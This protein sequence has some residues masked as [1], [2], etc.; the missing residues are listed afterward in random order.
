M[1]D[2]VRMHHETV[3]A[4]FARLDIGDK[5]FLTVNDLR[6]NLGEDFAGVTAEDLL[7]EADPNGTGRIYCDQFMEY[8]L[9]DEPDKDHE[10]DRQMFLTQ[11]RQ[12]ELWHNWCKRAE[13]ADLIMHDN[14]TRT[15]GHRGTLPDAWT[16]AHDDLDK[17]ADAKKGFGKSNS[18]H[19]IFRKG[20]QTP[21][22][23]PAT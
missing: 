10:D 7:A 11:K 16:K 15:E 12:D 5:G 17:E 23:K 20:L 18:L 9:H 19:A 13:F 4:A 2:R 1:Q 3:R 6:K 14:T 21:S 8:L 22:P